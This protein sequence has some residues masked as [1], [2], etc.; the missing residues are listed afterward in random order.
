MI[1]PTSGS[2]AKAIARE[3]PSAFDIALLCGLVHVDATM[4][5]VCGREECLAVLRH[6]EALELRN[7]RRGCCAGLARVIAGIVL[8]HRKR[9]RCIGVA[10]GAERTVAAIVCCGLV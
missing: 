9:R 4:V 7:G 3:T 8:H 2:G 6:L 1:E 5:I 10:R